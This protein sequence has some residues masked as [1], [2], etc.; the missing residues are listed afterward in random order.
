MN[1]I[2][3]AA[4]LALIAAPAMAES[5]APITTI[6]QIADLDLSIRAGQRALDRRLSLAA[7]EVCGVASDS[8]LLG[9]NEVRRCRK[10]V[11]AQ[12]ARERDERI[13][14]ASERP[15]LIAAR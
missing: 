1:K 12:V 4:L 5:P 10:D 11:L 14:A 9:Q 8:D 6:V 15:I 7:K 13:A 2:F 3:S